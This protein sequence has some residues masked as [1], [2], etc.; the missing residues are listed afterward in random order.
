[1]RELRYIG[2]ISARRAPTGPPR[3]KDREKLRSIVNSLVAGE[4][5]PARCRPHRLV[6]NRHPFLGM[7]HFWECHIEWDWL[8][9][10]EDDG[11]TITLRRTGTH[12]DIFG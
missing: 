11:D 7:P 6:G 5:L 12:S 3:G 10:W 8:P 9:V 2:L 4:T 1:M